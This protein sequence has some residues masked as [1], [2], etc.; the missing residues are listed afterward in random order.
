MIFLFQEFTFDKR[1][2][3]TFNVL[4]YFMKQLIIIIFIFKTVFTLSQSFPNDKEK[5]IK[6]L[7]EIY[8]ENESD[9]VKNFANDVIKVN[10]LKN[11]I[12]DDASFTQ[13]VNTCNALQ[14]NSLKSYPDIFNYLYSYNHLISK[15]IS[16]DKIENWHD[17]IDKLIEN[18][19]KS[20]D[21]FLKFSIQF[22]LNSKISDASNSKW[23]YTNGDFLFE[24]G[25]SVSV[26]LENGNLRCL[27]TEKSSGANAQDSIVIHKTNGKLD[28]Q[29]KKWIGSGGTIN[30]SKTGVDENKMFATLKN[31][32]QINTKSSEVK[33]DSVLLT[34]P[35]FQNPVYGTI[36][37]RTATYLRDID[38]IYPRFYSYTKEEKV[39]NIMDGIDYIG[40]FLIEGEK[41]IGKGDNETPS[42][43]IIKRNNKPFIVASAQVFQFTI[44][45]IQSSQTDIKILIGQDSISHN[46]INFNY[47]NSLKEIEI[48]RL[49]KGRGFAP[50]E[51]SYHQLD[52]HA[53]RILY[54][55]GTNELRFTFD[56]GAPM[57]LRNAKFESKNY[58]DEKLFESFK[59]MDAINPLTLAAKYASDKNTRQFTEGEFASA[60]NK[61]ITQ[62]KPLMLEMA[63][64]GFIQYDVDKKTVEIKDKLIKYVEYKSGQRD[65][66]NLSFISDLSTQLKSFSQQE[67]EVINSDKLLLANYNKMLANDNRRKKLPFYA[68]LDLN[69][70]NLIIDGVDYVT[71]SNAQPSYVSPTDLQIT[72]KANRSFTFDGIIHSGKMAVTTEIGEFNYQTNSFNIKNAKK[73]LLTVQPFTEKEKNGQTIEMISA[74]SNVYGTLIIDDINNRSGKNTSFTD[75]PKLSISKPCSIFYN[76]KMNGAYD[77]LRFFVTIDPFELDSLDNFNERALLLKGELTSAGIFPKLKEN[78]RIMDD[79]SFGFSTQAPEN[80]YKFYDGNT[81]YK[82]KILLSGN[83]LQ[84]AGTIAFLQSTAESNRLT[85]LPDSTIGIAKFV[86]NPTEEKL[87]LPDVYNDRS[88]ICY[89]P[90]S[91]ILKASSTSENPM[92][93]FNNESHL[94]GTLVFSEIEMTGKGE[95]GFKTA[96]MYSKH[97]K[98]N[99]WEILADTSS[100]LLKNTFREQGDDPLALKADGV[101]AKISFKT[102]K[103]EFNASKTK[104]IEF[105]SNLYY[106]QMDKF[107]WYMDELSI[108][109]E[110][111]KDGITSFE[112]DASGI[113]SN[114]YCYDPKIDS[115]RKINF[116]ALSARYDLK[117]QHIYCEKVVNLPVGDVL[118]HPD[119]NK[120]VIEKKARIRPLLNAQIETTNKKHYFEQ[121]SIDVLDKSNY[122]ATGKYKYVDVDKEIS[123]IQ[124]DEINCSNF[125]TKA[126]GIIKENRGF[127]LSKQFEYFGN[128]EILTKEDSILCDGSTRIVHDCKYKK[129]WM[130]FKD[131]IQPL[132][133]QIPIG[134]EI[135]NIDEQSLGLGFYWDKENKNLYTAFLSET[136]LP[137]DELV[138]SATGY[139]QFNSAKNE[140]QISTKDQ[141]K[142]RSENIAIDALSTMNYL[143][144]DLEN[145]NCTIYGEGEIKLGLPLGETNIESFGTIRYEASGNKKITLS[146]SSKFSFPVNQELME[147]L[148]KKMKVTEELISVK[149][150]DINRT[151]FDRAMKHWN[152]KKD[153][154]KIREAV[155]NETTPKFPKSMEQTIVLSGLEL[156]SYSKNENRGLKSTSPKIILVSMY[157]RPVFKQVPY[158]FYVDLTTEELNKYNFSLNFNVGALDYF[159]DLKTAKSTRDMKILTNDELFNK[160]LFEI[161]PKMK[162]IKNFSYDGTENPEIKET[163]NE[164]F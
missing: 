88:Y 104:Q 109:M 132:N 114:F 138:Y 134:K 9:K 90:K 126:V 18:K 39:S 73:V 125:N 83:G 135:K 144:M 107:F 124:M 51:D 101:T 89:L 27:M 52:I 156:E 24:Y 11:A 15:E 84:G 122:K 25:A 67:M 152:E 85:F 121:C 129:S 131:K 47:N 7:N 127:K 158:Q 117:T 49:S 46:S 110:R 96:S 113:I 10:L 43:V 163:F 44:N 164:I 14:E 148:A 72:L 141:L 22:F 36:E 37:D 115:L 69:T 31:N 76:D 147:G 75:Y 23:F 145:N 60:I 64:H 32:Y 162:K 87:Q 58:F 71:L 17:I 79:Y 29:S 92:R 54:G 80:G 50:F 143:S 45:A 95:M 102:R 68:I 94:S 21:D 41:L 16:N 118:I 65:F 56:Y 35:Y 149:E 70:S 106:C 120:L 111:N 153:Y 28:I 55:I 123:L 34:A 142:Q 133:I 38:R 61:F 157:E 3:T 108:D 100:F 59:G 137:E 8:A 99:R 112:A 98:F 30:W 105:P 161:K 82:N 78:I 66:D 2:M 159:F 74:L 150:S 151:N 139:L 116:K 93:L 12:I 136:N 40:G 4:I 130:A 42:Q 119:S 160:T 77:S 154:D 62:C 19:N 63:V 86:N 81:N 57:D 91:K 140:F 155:L 20:T 103:G 33:L 6:Y 26:Q 97:Y 48:A 5:F 128:L 146:V 13:I 1:K 53:Q